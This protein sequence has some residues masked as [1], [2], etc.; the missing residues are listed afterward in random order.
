[1]FAKWIVVK[2]VEQ[3]NSGGKRENLTSAYHTSQ[4]KVAILTWFQNDKGYDVSKL[5]GHS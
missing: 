4:A 2:I 5:R 1:M 3:I